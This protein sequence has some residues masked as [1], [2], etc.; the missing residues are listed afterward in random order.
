MCRGGAVTTQCTKGIRVV[1]CQGRFIPRASTTYAVVSASSVVS[2]AASSGVLHGAACS[3]PCTTS[4][5]VVCNDARDQD[6]VQ[7][8]WRDR[9][10]QRCTGPGEAVVVIV[11]RHADHIPMRVFATTATARLATGH[12]GLCSHVYGCMWR[13]ILTH[14]EALAIALFAS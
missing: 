11:V 5:V 10:W 12:T 3:T 6:H 9:Q 7:H 8:G 2:V 14:L 1:L 13:I 4:C